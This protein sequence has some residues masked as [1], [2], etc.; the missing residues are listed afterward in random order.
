MAAAP[1]P[2]P[3]AMPVTKVR[4]Y[5]PGS[6]GN[7]GPGLDILGCALT[8]AG[9]V[10]EAALATERGVRI[11]DPGHPDLSADSTRHASAIAARA[12]LRLANREDVGVVLDV[13]KGLPLAGGQ[14]GSAASAVAGA[15]AASALLGAPLD[16]TR[17]LEAALEAESRVAG[18]HADNVAPALLGGIV[19]ILSLE[20][21]D[22]VRLPVPG[23]L[24]VV[25]VHPAQRL[26]TK[27]ARSVLPA[28]LDR[29][30]AFEQA[31]RVAA[32][33]AAL[34]TGDLALLARAVD[35]RVAE[36]ARAPLLRGFGEAK[37]AALRAGALGCSISGAGP[38]SFALSDD[39]ARADRIAAAMVEAY[40]H[41]GVQ[42]TARVA[43]IDERGAR[44]E[45]LVS[46]PA[47]AAPATH[48]T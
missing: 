38:T 45:V 44:L 6:V 22:I 16:Y 37:A 24:R 36:P 19:L 21:L 20:P 31:A 17:L 11:H 7:I 41:A 23:E 3:S 13:R 27:E 42:A 32:M 9:D 10:V 39:D 8:G 29:R 5:A 14:G 1:A 26:S 34:S 47:D 4:A 35:D 48:N 33:V 25:L 15:L 40:Q 2:A 30:A 12:V 28:A 18:R 46:G 43:R